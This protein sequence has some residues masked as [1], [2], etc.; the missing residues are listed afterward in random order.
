[1]QK[2]QSIYLIYAYM[3]KGKYLFQIN[4]NNHTKMLSK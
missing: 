4:K 2:Q 1:M 3:I